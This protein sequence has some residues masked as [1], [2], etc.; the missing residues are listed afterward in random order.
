MSNN[1]PNNNTGTESKGNGQTLS[2]LD[3]NQAISFHVKDL[4][5][6]LLRNIHW[7]IIFAILGGFIMNFYSR[8]QEKV[9]ESHANI[10]IRN[11]NE[12]GVSDS[13][14]RELSVRTALGLQ[15]F[16]TSTINNEMIIPK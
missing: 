8:R 1:L 9:Y 7:L 10:L 4:V 13:D 6:L 14:T 12:V 5:F 3:E 15:S 2:F 16:Y 11:G